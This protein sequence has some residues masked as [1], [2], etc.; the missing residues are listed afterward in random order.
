MDLALT[1]HELTGMQYHFEQVVEANTKFNLTRI[2]SPEHAAVLHYAD[3]LALVR[4]I[5]AGGLEPGW[6]L[7]IGTGAGFPSV[8]AALCLPD[9]HV[10]AM[11]GRHRKTDFVSSVA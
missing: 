10:V 5:R 7:D 1:P 11:D 8:V 2:V 6:L 4:W 9:W 3:S